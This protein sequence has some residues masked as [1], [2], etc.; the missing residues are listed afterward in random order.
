ML[1][2]TLSMF[3]YF[4]YFT[5]LN[6]VCILNYKINLTSIPVSYNCNFL[7]ISSDVFVVNSNS[8]ILISRDEKSQRLYPQIWSLY[9]KEK[10]RCGLKAAQIYK[11]P[12]RAARDSMQPPAAKNSLL[13]N[14]KMIR[15]FIVISSLLVW[16]RGAALA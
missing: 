1:K 6:G 10:K 16:V 14:G 13:S 11:R 3:I 2:K 7:S 12:I 5:I 4:P 9:N 15:T 8:V